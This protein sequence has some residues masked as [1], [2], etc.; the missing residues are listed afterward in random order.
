VVD[1]NHF[2]S[3]SKRGTQVAAQEEPLALGFAPRLRR[4]RRLDRQ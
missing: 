2:G 3:R 1:R 4:A